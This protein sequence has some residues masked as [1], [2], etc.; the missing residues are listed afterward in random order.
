MANSLNSSKRITGLD[1]IK[2]ICIILVAASHTCAVFSIPFLGEFFH[3]VFLKSF[4]LV[5][6]FTVIFKKNI[7]FKTSV[8]NRFVSLAVPYF[9]FSVLVILF[10][11][12]IAV[13]FENETVS[14]SY[15]GWMLIARDVFC[16]FSGIGIGT[17]WFLP[18]LFV[19][20]LLLLCGIRL[21]KDKWWIYGIITVGMIVLSE[22]T[23]FL[24]ADSG[25][26][27]G[28]VIGEYSYT[29]S[30]ICYGTGYAYAGYLL[31]KVYTEHGFDK[32]IALCACILLCA[33]IITRSEN[34]LIALAENF[35]FCTVMIWL[36]GFDCKLYSVMQW[37][38]TNSLAFTIYHYLFLY[39]LL[40]PFFDDGL[41]FF[42]CIMLTT[43]I[44]IL[45][46][47]RFPW[48]EKILGKIRRD[49]LTVNG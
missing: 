40:K 37:Y 9:I 13:I 24:A 48:H 11:I 8:K 12:V 49:R 33:C 21:A 34:L 18:V 1:L 10:H 5:S 17:L 47:N 7:G 46:L 32:R 28:K 23:S 20:F 14:S 3:N 35:C 41:P 25:T 27:I 2:G 4:F 26:M 39:P 30:R 44:L 6:G 43:T 42:L 19:S 16:M 15:T 22:H 31:G 38:G 45:V 36:G 29:L